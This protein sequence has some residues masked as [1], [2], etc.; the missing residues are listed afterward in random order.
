MDESIYAYARIGM[1]H[2]MLYPRCMNDPDD[3]VATLEQFIRRDDIETFD[4]CVPY[5][6]HRRERLLAQLGNCGKDVVYAMHLFPLRKI[7]L[8]SPDFQE[9]SVT[10][11]ILKD[12]VAMAAASGA[13]GFI[14]VSGI[15]LPD[16]REDARASFREFCRW[17][18]GELAPHRITALLEPFD[19]TVAK[20]FLYGPIE[21]CVGLVEEIRGEGH[22]IGL[23]LDI[24]HLPLMDEDLADAIRRCGR[25]IKR[26]HL[27]NC[28]LR[29][30][31]DP[32]Y[33]DCHPPIGYPGGEI[34]VPEL[35]VVLRELLR[36]GYLSKRERGALILEMIPYPGRSVEDTVRYSFEKL[37]AAWQRV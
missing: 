5:G 37:A 16:R 31:T 35:A 32:L 27:G 24:A 3:H 20:K 29:D 22:D 11:L 19:R 36:T 7:S 6:D 2:H 33:G 17:F 9:Q 23:E 28:V 13:T 15:D 14:F 25:H 4:Y 18:C 1:V 30:K 8:S 21:E 10:R 34:D 26:V 12:Q